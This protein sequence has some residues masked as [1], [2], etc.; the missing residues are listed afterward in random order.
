MQLNLP[1]SSLK[2]VLVRFALKGDNQRNIRHQP[3]E[4]HV[5]IVR[6]LDHI[7]EESYHVDACGSHAL[8]ACRPQTPECL[9]G[10]TVTLAG[11]NRNN[12]GLHATH[13]QI[14]APHKLTFCACT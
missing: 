1:N 5:T 8:N 13:A 7:D 10:T 6:L 2:W 11:C 3:I 12:C 4:A 14:L 9:Q